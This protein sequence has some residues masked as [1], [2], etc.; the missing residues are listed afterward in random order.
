M[1]TF[2]SNKFQTGY[3]TNLFSC[4]L[5]EQW[6]QEMKPSTNRMQHSDSEAANLEPQGGKKGKQYEEKRAKEIQLTQSKAKETWDL[7]CFIVFCVGT[8]KVIAARPFGEE[9]AL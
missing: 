2:V 6:P 4:D 1:W 5:V 3:V 9:K 7:M 8:E